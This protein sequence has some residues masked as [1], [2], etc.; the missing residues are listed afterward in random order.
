MGTC[1]KRGWFTRK[2][3]KVALKK[4]KG[5]KHRLKTVYK[6]P[7]CDEWH[8]SHLSIKEYKRKVADYILIK[9]LEDDLN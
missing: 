9:F 3:A 5:G 8:L 4:Q 7:N 6:C 2:Q 1:Y